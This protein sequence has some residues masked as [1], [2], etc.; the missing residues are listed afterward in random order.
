MLIHG[1]GNGQYLFEQLRGLADDDRMMIGIVR[2]GYFSSNGAESTGPDSDRNFDHYTRAVTD[3]LA[4]AITQVKNHYQPAELIIL[5]HS[6]GA[7]LAGLIASFYPSLADRIILVACPCNVPQWRMLRDGNNEPWP[8][9][10]SPHSVVGQLNTGVPLLAVVGADDTNTFPQLTIDYV[11]LAQSAGVTASH[12][13]V[14]G[15]D[16]DGI[17]VNTQALID[18]VFDWIGSTP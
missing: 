17:V 7:A 16:H 3:T 4:V 11:A 18:I 13:V 6:G 1:D 2:P 5:G 10:L 12:E 15:A 9:S 14:A 8:R